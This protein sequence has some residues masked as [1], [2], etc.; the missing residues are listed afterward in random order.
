MPLY[1]YQCG[2]CGLF[3]QWRSM[4]EATNPMHC[5]TCDAIAKR[6][7][8]P[9]SVL[10]SSSLRLSNSS[11]EPKRVTRSQEPTPPRVQ[12]HS[13]GRPWMISH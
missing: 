3:E 6:I 10:L 12:S 4:A 9:P 11:A 5:P 13:H 1:E 7:F 2:S 8:S